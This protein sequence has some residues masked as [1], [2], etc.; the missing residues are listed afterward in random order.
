MPHGAG[1]KGKGTILVTTQ[2]FGKESAHKAIPAHIDELAPVYSR[3][4]IASS[5]SDL[6]SKI[7]LLELNL[8][9]YQLACTTYS[10]RQISA[11]T[12]NFKF[13]VVGVS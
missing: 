5:R 7:S 2:G 6:T 9:F 10:P 1:T 13:V 4:S 11:T 12:S 8:W 3:P